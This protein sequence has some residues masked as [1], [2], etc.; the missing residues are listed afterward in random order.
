VQRIGFILVF[1]MFGPVLSLAQIQGISENLKNRHALQE[2]IKGSAVIRL[3]TADHE[4][5][6]G[7]VHGIFKVV[8]PSIAD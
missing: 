6:N 2:L 4:Q 8:Y 7:L 5:F 3:S 1:L